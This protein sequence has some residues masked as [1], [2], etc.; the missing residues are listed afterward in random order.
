MGLRKLKGKPLLALKIFYT[1][2][3]M[4]VF[5]PI[6][7]Y[8]VL[9]LFVTPAF[10]L[11]FSSNDGGYFR[12]IGFMLLSGFALLCFLILNAKVFTEKL[13][14]SELPRIIHI[15]VGIGCILCTPFI[16]FYGFGLIPI[17]LV[18]CLYYL[19]DHNHKQNG[20][21]NPDAQNP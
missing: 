12:L 5:L 7:C 16:I 1:I 20:S 11:S 13:H 4:I 2:A 17:A 15:G 10:F 14:I 19:S 9:G 6:L 8:W 21:P 3:V 18:A